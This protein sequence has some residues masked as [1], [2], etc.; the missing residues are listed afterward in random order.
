MKDS[1]ING[2]L[3]DTTAIIDFFRGSKHV[4]A[5]L[6]T[7]K[8]KGLL[9]SCP[10]TIAETF[11]G[12]RESENKKVHEFLSSLVFYPFTYES[13]RLAGRWRYSYARKGIILSLSDTLI[14]ALAVENRL[15]LVTANKR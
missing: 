11:A 8:N 5:L 14:A 15:A 2:F 1:E 3:L 6:E 12:A 9:A 4:A 10:V 13:A 7:I